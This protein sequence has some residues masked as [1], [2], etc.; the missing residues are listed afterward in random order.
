MASGEGWFESR[1]VGDYHEDQD[2]HEHE[3]QHEDEP[4]HEHEHKRVVMMNMW[5]T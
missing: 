1:H 2:E 3:D 5:K 4:E